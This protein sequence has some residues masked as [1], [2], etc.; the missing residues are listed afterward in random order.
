M[1]KRKTRMDEQQLD[2]LRRKLKEVRPHPA[3]TQEQVEPLATGS[4]AIME[5]WIPGTS[6]DSSAAPYPRALAARIGQVGGNQVLQRIIQASRS[7]VPSPASPIIQR[8]LLDHHRT[9]ENQI[10]VRV[11]LP[12]N[13]QAFT[14]DVRQALTSYV[15]DRR[16]A[17]FMAALRPDLEAYYGEIEQRVPELEALTL[18][19]GINPDSVT[20]RLVRATNPGNPGEMLPFGVEVSARAT[21]D[22][23]PAEA[24]REAPPPTTAHPPA[25]ESAEQAAAPV[26]EQA[27]TTTTARPTAG[28]SAEQAAA[29]ASVEEQA[30]TP[31]REEETIRQEESAQAE[32][33]AP[34]P[35]SAPEMPA[36]TIR[37]P[38]SLTEV[39]LAPIPAGP[40]I[41][42]PT[43]KL[44]AQGDVSPIGT[45]SNR[46]FRANLGT[47]LPEVQQ[48]F[49]DDYR[50]LGLEYTAT[51]PAVSFRDRRFDMEMQLKPGNIIEFKTQPIQ[52]THNFREFGFRTQLTVSVTLSMQFTGNPQFLEAIM[53]AAGAAASVY[54]FIQ[55]VSRL[56]TGLGVALENFFTGVAAIGSRVFIPVILLP[57]EAIEEILQESGPGGVRYGGIA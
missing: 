9:E 50:Q 46:E 52:I 2:N 47:G 44:E 12:A 25:G 45:T 51:G 40:V 3:P 21:T 34:A 33:A 10:E 48:T 8:E 53:M 1:S 4:Q 57:R 23:A 32:S 31:A 41:I 17:R 37:I 16:L 42:N 11:T 14:T 28:E 29:P 43:Y 20:A 5:G 22:E 19:I 26:E 30:P 7:G 13:F 56:G 55:T 39:P 18:E 15:S 27:P 35:A 54:A 49:Q 6:E 38:R 36:T 24:V